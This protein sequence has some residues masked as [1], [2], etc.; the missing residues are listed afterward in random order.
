MSE[1]E[2]QDSSSD[3]RDNSVNMQHSELIICIDNPPPL[4]PTSPY[5]GIV[6]EPVLM[7]NII[8]VMNNEEGFW[9]CSICAVVCEA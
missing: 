9:F 7:Q 5:L 1:R 3:D 2:M 6:F 8:N 4:L